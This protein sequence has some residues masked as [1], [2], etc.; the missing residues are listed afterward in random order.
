MRR[1]FF[2]TL[3]ASF[4][5]ATFFADPLKIEPLKELQQKVIQPSENYISVGAEKKRLEDLNAMTLMLGQRD[6][7][8]SLRLDRHVAIHLDRSIKEVYGQASLLYYPLARDTIYGGLGLA[9]G[10]HRGYAEYYTNAGHDGNS[11]FVIEEGKL[12]LTSNLPLT[13]GYSF[14]LKSGQEQFIQIRWAFGYSF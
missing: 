12:K 9:L 3:I 13:L 7:S 4:P 6:L 10:L 5:L 1:L 2:H 11:I 14:T 8:G